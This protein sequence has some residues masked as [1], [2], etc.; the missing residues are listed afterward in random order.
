MKSSIKSWLAILMG[1]IILVADFWW[2]YTSYFDATW[3]ALGVLI[4]VADLVWIVL[5]LSLM[6]K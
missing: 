3:L 2:T 1:L 4:F 5:D 6:K